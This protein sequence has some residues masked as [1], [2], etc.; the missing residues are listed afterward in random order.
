MKTAVFGCGGRT[1]TYD[2]R[3]MSCSLPNFSLQHK[4]FL[5]F[6]PHFSNKPG[7]HQSIRA[8]SVHLLLSPYGS[9]YGSRNRIR[10]WNDSYLSLPKHVVGSIKESTN[11]SAASVPD[12]DYGSPGPDVGTEE[13]VLRW[14]K[15]RYLP[16]GDV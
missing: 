4:D 16:Q 15:V 3:V 1:R 6:L 14:S 8:C 11:Y 9:A 12:T 7:G 13:A 2:L 5:R 10:F